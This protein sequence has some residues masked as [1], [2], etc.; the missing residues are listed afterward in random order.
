MWESAAG[1]VGGLWTK[2]N[3]ASP[4]LPESRKHHIL[5]YEYKLLENHLLSQLNQKELH[6]HNGKS[7]TFQEWV[8][9]RDA[10]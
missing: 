1:A 10:T 9:L 2:A 4:H 7:K 6:I 8:V 5:L 3:S